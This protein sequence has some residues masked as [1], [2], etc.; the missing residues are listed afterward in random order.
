V[1]LFPQSTAIVLA[2][3][4]LF[5]PLFG[6]FAS[7]ECQTAGVSFAQAKSCDDCCTPDP[8]CS[9]SSRQGSAQPVLPASVSRLSLSAENFLADS[10]KLLNLLYAPFGKEGRPLFIAS[11]SRSLSSSL[12]QLCI[13][14][15]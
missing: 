6:T 7:Q 13:R 12:A 8:C 11:A 3:A 15:I 5:V 2:L 14:L 1:K 4:F 10:S 9:V